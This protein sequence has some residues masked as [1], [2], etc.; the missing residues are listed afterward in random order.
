LSPDPD[1]TESR[2][3]PEGGLQTSCC[4][5]LYDPDMD[6]VHDGF[7]LAAFLRINDYPCQVRRF[8]AE[9]LKSVAAEELSE[10]CERLVF[11][12][13]TPDSLPW[14]LG[15]ARLLRRRRLVF[16]F[17]RAFGD[18]GI[19]GCVDGQQVDGVLVGDPFPVARVIARK[20]LD[21]GADRG[22]LKGAGLYLPGEPLLPQP[23]YRDLD[24]FPPADYAF[25]DDQV[26]LAVPLHGSRGHPW[27]LSFSA[28]RAWEAPLRQQ[29]P[30]RILADMQLYARH[31]GA[32]HFVFTD[33][34]A[35]GRPETLPELARGILDAGL[36]VFW[37]ARIWPDPELDRGTLQLLRRAGC[38]ALELDFF[39]GSDR[40]HRLLST[41]VRAGEAARLLRDCA[42]E[43]IRAG[44]GV[45]VGFPSET[46]DDRALTLA[47][48]QRQAEALFRVSDTSAC[49]IQPGAPLRRERG[50]VFPDGATSDQWHDGEHNNES[51]R[52]IWLKELNT[53]TRSLDLWAPG[54]PR[55]TGELERQVLS[56]LRARVEGLLAGD[57]GWRA[58]HL[59]LAGV[60]HGR[61]A[62]CGPATLH[63][64]LAGMQT[65]PALGLL[66]QAAASG[67][68]QVVLGP[69]APAPETEV[70]AHPGLL[71]VLDRGR[72]LRLRLVLRSGLSGVDGDRLRAVA[73]RVQALLLEGAG[74]QDWER[75]ER[76]LPVV[77]EQRASDLL[78]LP[79][80]VVRA[81]I[82]AACD[83][84]AGLLSRLA[85]AGAD[86][87]SLALQRSGETRLDARQRQ[88]ARAGL[89]RLLSQRGVFSGDLEGD[90]GDSL[91]APREVAL[92]KPRGAGWPAGF[93][94][95]R[96]EQG[97]WTCTCPAGRRS[98]ELRRHP[99]DPGARYARFAPG[100]CR[101]CELL[102]DC[103]LD[104]DDFSVRLG[105]TM[106]ASPS[107]LLADLEDPDC[108]LGRA[109]RRM[110]AQPCLVGWDEARVDGGGQLWVCPGCGTEPVGD[111]LESSL[112]AV[113]YS[114]ELNEL[115]RMSLGASMAL[116]YLD[117]QQCA[118]G[119]HRVDRNAR[120]LA[121][122]A[123]LSPG[124]RAA[125]ESVGSGDRLQL[126]EEPQVGDGGEGDDG[127]PRG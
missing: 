76:W 19:R 43:G 90:H 102:S 47:W 52:R 42:R 20:V 46:D 32:R 12:G 116:P 24:V 18:P 88:A 50:L 119:C 14:V 41:G 16:I 29:A 25:H 105:L 8:D 1:T 11:L 68:R 124:Q 99:A 5:G 28:R 85:A 63:L 7:T 89:Q 118:M 82:G 54:E 2:P 103:P 62:F 96:E 100:D 39:C 74:E 65:G 57:P 91:E 92:L 60:M 48:L 87:V 33:M 115:R 22:E 98:S 106:L 23:P 108:G 73:P 34:V 27:P 126:N 71:E 101:H 9:T 97:G 44:V 78:A 81:R 36:R 56:R 45:T 84:P 59:A 127:H 112:G 64:D 70:L 13:A 120:L 77:A 55:F 35:N 83:D 123:A 58:D 61:E 104:R 6:L 113:W 114:R 4:V 51:Q 111:V 10:S 17:G 80:I 3:G 38:R 110:D 79:R 30:A 69:P 26:A 37:R 122:L 21:G 125:L 95:E 94:L 121:R 31:H 117:R 93:S 107:G 15:A 109:T 40:L 49:S 67:T 66:E 72:D 86:L 53:W 75:F